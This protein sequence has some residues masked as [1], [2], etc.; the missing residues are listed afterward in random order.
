MSTKKAIIKSELSNEIVGEPVTKPKGRKASKTEKLDTTENIITD[1][2]K[3]KTK[4]EKTDEVEPIKKTNTRKSKTEKV[5]DTVEPT[6]KSK[7]KINAEEST[8]SKTNIDVED[9]SK[10]KTTIDVEDSKKIKAKKISEPEINVIDNVEYN[11]LKVEWAI[12]CDKIKEANR[13]KELLEIQKNQLLNKLWKLG[14][15][16]YP[17]TDIF[18]TSE[19]IKPPVK[20]SS[21]QTKILNNNSSES[22]NDNS[23]ESD[24]DSDSEIKRPTKLKIST[25][26]SINTD[27]DTSDSDSD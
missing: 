1:E 10:T 16:N 17:K 18:E 12:L 4:P 26:K 13:E 24:S 11:T 25:K 21:I 9:T 14:E 7:K 19:K 3:K 23:D 22:S 20:I 6:K 5:D 2:N 8:K 15:T 27:S